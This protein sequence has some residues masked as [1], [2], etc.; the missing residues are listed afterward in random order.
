MPMNVEHYPRAL[1][2][3]IPCLA[4]MPIP[5]RRLARY[6]PCSNRKG[7]FRTSFCWRV[8]SRFPGCLKENTQYPIGWYLFFQQINKFKICYGCFYSLSILKGFYRENCSC[9]F[10]LQRRCPTHDSPV[11]RTK[12]HR[13]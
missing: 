8:P 2:R 11:F 3:H 10:R 4:N 9:H 12:K 6:P 13:S 5:Q 7:L 1:Y